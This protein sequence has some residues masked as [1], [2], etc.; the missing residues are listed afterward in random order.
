MMCTNKATSKAD[1]SVLAH[2]ITT[3]LADP[4]FLSHIRAACQFFLSTRAACKE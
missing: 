4:G 1:P 3:L 2:F